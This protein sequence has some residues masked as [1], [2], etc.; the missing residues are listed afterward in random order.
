MITAAFDGP[1][2]VGA[3]KGVELYALADIDDLSNFGLGSANNGG[4]TDGEEFVLPAVPLSAGSYIFVTSDDTGAQVFFESTANNYNAGSAISINGDDA[5]ELFEF[6]IVID[7]FGDINMDGTGTAWDHLDSWAHR[8]CEQ[9]PNGGVFDAA[10]W[11]FGGTNVFDGTMLNAE[12]AN[13]MPVGAYEATC[14]S[15]VFGCTNPEACNFNMNAT[16]D[17][18]SCE[19]IGDSCDDGNPL[20]END[21]LQ[22]DCS[23]AGT[24]V[25]TCDPVAWS[26]ATV[27]TNSDMD[28]WIDNGDG[29]YSANGFCGGGCQEVVDLWLVSNGFD[30]SSVTTSS[31]VFSLSE[32]FGSTVL[33]LQYTTSYSGDPAASTWTSLGTYD[34]AG[35]YTADLSVLAGSPEVYFAFQYADDG[36]D[37]YSNFVLSDLALT[38]DC[39]AD[40]T[41]F[42]CPLEMV[43]F[44]DA[45]DDGDA[46]TNNDLIQNDCTCAG[47]P[48]VLTNSCL[49]YT[50]DAA[51]DLTRTVPLVI[52]LATKPNINTTPLS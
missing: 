37:G 9:T 34:A 40:V 12:A 52:R 7:V 49:L 22:A 4:G 31:L 35:G 3:P 36:A 10:N 20:T 16:D 13:P 32:N 2:T 5:V 19:L 25:A 46:M 11:T 18:G 28:M 39:P 51:D 27:A 1:L 17:D 23:C 48:F 33:D 29:S 41:V 44:G 26:I 21:V 47:T 30:Y 15:V 43:N 38:G 8:N 14:P 24:A 42:D 45:C 6:G 50:S